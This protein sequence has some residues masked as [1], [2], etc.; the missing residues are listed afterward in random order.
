[1]TRCIK[2][3]CLCACLLLVSCADKVGILS[4]PDMDAEPVLVLR[5]AEVREPVPDQFVYQ[6]DSRPPPHDMEVDAAPAI[7]C[8]RYGAHEPCQ[9]EG[10]LGPCAESTR[11][12]FSTEWSPCHQQNF[13]RSE[14]CDH[15]DNDCD[16]SLNEAPPQSQLGTLAVEC[17]DGPPE[18]LKVGL[19]HAGV[20]FCQQLRHDGPPEEQYGFGTC[21]N[22][23]LPAFDEECDG[24]DNDCDT[25]TDEG[26][27]NACGVCGDVP[28]EVCDT[29]D[30]DCD[31]NIDEGVLNACNECGVVPDE[32]CD[33]LDNDCDGAV[34]ENMGDCIC[35]N[36]LY[37]PQPEI[38]DGIDQDCDHRVDEGDD[39]GPLTKLC[40]VDVATDEVIVYDRREDGPQYVGGVCRLGIA[41]CGS[42][43][44]FE[45]P[46]E[47][48]YGYFECLEEIRP[49]VE[50][51][52]EADD[53]CDGLSDEGFGQGQVAVLMVIDVSGSMQQQE[54]TT[55]FEATRNTVQALHNRGANSI[56]YM[57]AIVGND[58][59]DDPY[60]YAPA[61]NCVPGIEDPPVPPLEDMRAA[62]ESLMM[63]IAAGQINRGGSS[64]NTYD[65]IGKFFTDDLID[66]DRDGILDDVEWSTS[67]GPHR[68]D[69]SA[70]THRIVVVLGDE[71]GQGDEYDH[72]NAARAMGQAH[73]ITYIIGPDE[74]VVMG[75]LV[76][77]SYS[78]LLEIGGVYVSMGAQRFNDPDQHQEIADGIQQALEEADCINGHQP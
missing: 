18:T 23:M 11:I 64:E 22:Q 65:A 26:V 2:F 7:V 34:D 72:H 68:I 21:A 71:R 55:A 30:N 14:V 46:G 40:S 51:C 1:M 24:F 50:R 47:E 52:N 5:D 15:L 78:Q 76:R 37:V 57:L 48:I 28:L 6:W 69:L 66:W 13:P 54:L 39:G 42:A 58:H 63:E 53:D 74:N 16:G 4:Q 33:F 61:H 27:L 29:V 12:C 60:L 3:K 25:Q 75:R 70:Y 67:V 62:I 19:C 20:A 44:D 59:M 77:D 8:P 49:G 35:D 43:L 41:F 36:P 31:E 32:L 73:G 9:I 56:C 10:L 17:Y 45:N 38:C